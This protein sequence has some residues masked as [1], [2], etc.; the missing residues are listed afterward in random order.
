MFGLCLGNFACRKK[1][2]ILCAF[3]FVSSLHAVSAVH[4][5]DYTCQSLFKFLF[6]FV[7]K[8]QKMWME[9]D[10]ILC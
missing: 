8:L 1:N 6:C 5:D 2:T 3:N 7:F 9:H 4:R 10:E